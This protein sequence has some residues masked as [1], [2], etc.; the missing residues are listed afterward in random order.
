MVVKRL[1]PSNKGQ[2]SKALGLELQ[3]KIEI[4]NS[5]NNMLEAKYIRLTWTI[6]YAPNGTPPIFVKYFP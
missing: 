2:A 1:A 3:R 5:V 4:L 6:A